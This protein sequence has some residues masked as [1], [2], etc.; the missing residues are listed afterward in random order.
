MLHTPT[1]VGAAGTHRTARAA[2]ARCRLLGMAGPCG[3]AGLRSP[4]ALVTEDGRGPRSL[5]ACGPQLPREN[6][7]ANKLRAPPK[8]AHTHR[9]NPLRRP[10]RDESGHVRSTSCPQIVLTRRMK[11]IGNIQ[12]EHFFLQDQ[13]L[14]FAVTKNTPMFRRLKRP[15]DSR[16]GG[17]REQGANPGRLPCAVPVR[18]AAHGLSSTSAAPCCHRTD[19][20]GSGEEP[21]WGVFPA[22]DRGHRREGC[23]QA[24]RAG[25]R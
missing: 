2:P 17:R 5:S 25:R 20:G 9:R 14:Y 7:A 3:K 1:A 16:G 24:A 6:E 10:Q 22:R 21:G 8:D 11:V 23:G 12:Y 19:A 13:K 18:G 15:R 4:E